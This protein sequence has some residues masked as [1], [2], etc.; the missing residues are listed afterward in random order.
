M[1]AYSAWAGLPQAPCRTPTLPEQHGS[2]LECA[3]KRRFPSFHYRIPPPKES[4]TECWRIAAY[5]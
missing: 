3:Q 2:R 5:E 1:V 4:I